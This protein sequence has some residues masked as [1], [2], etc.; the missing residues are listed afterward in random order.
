MERS[1]GSGVGGRRPL[2]GETTTFAGDPQIEGSSEKRLANRVKTRGCEVFSR[3]KRGQHLS[4]CLK[5]G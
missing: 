1:G 3:G 5:T 4:R 2:W